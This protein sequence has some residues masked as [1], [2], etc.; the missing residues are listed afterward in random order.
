M[1]RCL[2][3]LK[4]NNHVAQKRL[5]KLLFRFRKIENNNYVQDSMMKKL[6]LIMKCMNEVLGEI[7]TQRY[8]AILTFTSLTR[9]YCCRN[10]NT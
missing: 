7:S 3:Y 2:C 10:F 5:S 8:V 9:N 1:D 6:V 4:R